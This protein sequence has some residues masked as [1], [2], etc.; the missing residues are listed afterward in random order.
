MFQ[1]SKTNSHQFVCGF[2]SN[3]SAQP[4]YQWSPSRS[5][6]PVDIPD[7]ALYK[8]RWGIV[9]GLRLRGGGETATATSGWNNNNTNNSTT[10]YSQQNNSSAPPSQTPT[11][12]NNNNA[13]TQP[14]QPPAPAGSNNFFF[15]FIAIYKK[16]CALK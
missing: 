2:S 1:S 15:N 11:Q 3:N 8:V 5:Q 7:A 6:T 13:N 14:P 12:W 9:A 16:C 10:P 4:Q